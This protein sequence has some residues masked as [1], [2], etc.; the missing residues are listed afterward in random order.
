MAGGNAYNLPGQTDADGDSTAAPSAEVMELL[1]AGLRANRPSALSPILVPPPEPE[2]E[3]TTPSSAMLHVRGIGADG[4]DGTPD[5]KGDYENEAALKMLFQPFGDFR[6]ATI[7]HRIT[8]GQN[9]SWAL[10]TMGNAAAVD[11]IL[12][13][14]AEAPIFAG[15]TKLVLNR[16]SQTQ[17]K[18]STGGMANVRQQDA[19]RRTWPQWLKSAKVQYPKMQVIELQSLR[20]VF[21]RHAIRGRE[22][23][24]V[25]TR[26]AMGSLLEEAMHQIFVSWHG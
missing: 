7:R 24:L 3:L 23:E 20:S 18:L 19:E 10:V 15:N 11:S 8:D 13:S 22:S 26:S 4:W 1:P 25:V 16:F 12:Q 17:A 9:T 5:G 21:E 2:P 6:Q 14:H